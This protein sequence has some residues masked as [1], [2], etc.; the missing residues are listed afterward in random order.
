[1]SGNLE[2]GLESDAQIGIDNISFIVKTTFSGVFDHSHEKS[3]NGKKNETK[4]NSI[5]CKISEL[6]HFQKN[7]C[8]AFSLLLRRPEHGSEKLVIRGGC[9]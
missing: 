5:A 8:S 6:S 2:I 7:F 1:M 4:L 3:I 9:D